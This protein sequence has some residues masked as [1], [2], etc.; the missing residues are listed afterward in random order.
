MKNKKGKVNLV[1]GDVLVEI[2]DFPTQTIKVQSEFWELNFMMSFCDFE[3]F[4]KYLYSQYK[5]FNYIFESG[6]K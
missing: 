4:A 5:K 2:F 3:G 1:S 6:K